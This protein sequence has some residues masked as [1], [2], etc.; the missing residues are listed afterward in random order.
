MQCNT[1]YCSL[2]LLT[3]GVCCA[4][5]PSPL[6][7]LY[8]QKPP[9]L[10]VEAGSRALSA[11][12]E[13]A[14]AREPGFATLLPPP[15]TVKPPPGME[16]TT[17]FRYYNC[18]IKKDAP[19]GRVVQ[20]RVARKA[21]IDGETSDSDV[22]SSPPS[23]L[24]STS[25]SG[26]TASPHAKRV[27]ARNTMPALRPDV[28][29]SKV[30]SLRAPTVTYEDVDSDYEDVEPRMRPEVPA[31]WSC[32]QQQDKATKRKPPT[33]TVTRKHSTSSSH[34]SLHGQLVHTVSSGKTSDTSRGKKKTK[35]LF[36]IAFKS[37]KRNKRRGSKSKKA[38]GGCG[39]SSAASGN[40]SNTPRP[41][42][43][44]NVRCQRGS[45]SSARRSV[46]YACGQTARDLIP[47]FPRRL[48]A[49]SSHAP[50]MSLVPSHTLPIDGILPVAASAGQQQH[51]GPQAPEL[52][53]RNYATSSTP[54]PNTSAAAL[55]AKKSKRIS[56][57]NS[58]LHLS[59]LNNG[60]VLIGGFENESDYDQVTP[61]TEQPTTR[62]NNTTSHPLSRPTADSVG[63]YLEPSDGIVP[64]DNRQAVQS[65][66]KCASSEEMFADHVYDNVE[67]LQ[68][69]ACDASRSVSSSSTLGSNGKWRPPKPKRIRPL[70]VNQKP[71]LLPTTDGQNGGRPATQKPGGVMQSL[72]QSSAARDVYSPAHGAAHLKVHAT[73]SRT[74][75]VTSSVYDDVVVCNEPIPS[76]GCASQVPSSVASPRKQDKKPFSRSIRRSA[77][78]PGNSHMLFPSAKG[79]YPNQVVPADK[80]ERIHVRILGEQSLKTRSPLETPRK[81]PQIDANA[82]DS[83]AKRTSESGPQRT[84]ATTSR[85]NRGSVPKRRRS[86]IN[87]CSGV[88]TNASVAQPRLA[89][90][91][92]SIRTSSSAACGK[93]RG[94]SGKAVP[95]TPSGTTAAQVGPGTEHPPS[96][97]MW[98]ISPDALGKTTLR[99]PAMSTPVLVTKSTDR[100]DSSLLAITKGEVVFTELDR[101]LG[102]KAPCFWCYSAT[103]G[104]MGFVPASHG[105]LVH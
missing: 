46:T 103:S 40:S 21:A 90:R 3:L 80:I 10:K 28:T 86:F 99:P 20:A 9:V 14:A 100:S 33:L 34:S 68:E 6:A 94:N 74:L 53:H 56:Q 50:D 92:K 18:R 31:P 62:E 22:F 1:K 47:C 105:R 93:R 2:L 12:D 39:A 57:V 24:T 32:T 95:A 41:E 98:G 4:L 91:Q 27:D 49:L 42:D 77:K 78:C 64:V 65:N 43:S 96:A 15:S 59:F 73:V 48:N 87:A 102:E 11:V 104:K 75:S 38:D 19:P 37:K 88:P 85:G 72:K 30:T 58:P 51:G 67:E 66:S 89:V 26:S 97:T 83:S 5:Y 7:E 35:S 79:L 52:P 45:D 84:A 54:Q 69:P 55:T 60:E 71:G 23:T 17:S 63:N 8:A 13:G 101:M 82:Q 81:Q 25:S 61:E 16:V 44:A 36:C 29:P 70:I 76:S